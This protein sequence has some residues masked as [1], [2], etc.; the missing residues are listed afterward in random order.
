VAAVT[1]SRCTAR[2]ARRRRR[3]RAIAFAAVAVALAAS[4]SGS[5][6]ASASGSSGLIAFTVLTGKHT[7]IYSSRTDG[8]GRLRLTQGVNDEYCPTWSPDGQ[9]IALVVRQ[10]S[11]SPITGGSW[12]EVITARGKRRWQIGAEGSC[13]AWSPDGKWLAYFQDTDSGVDLNIVG[14]NGRGKRRLAANVD[15]R[16]YAGVPA[17]SPDSRELAYMNEGD[18]ATFLI[19]FVGVD[20]IRR[21]ALQIQ[22]APSFCSDYCQLYA[23]WMTWAPG[24][25][26]AFLIAG[27][28]LYPEVLYAIGRDG[29]NQRL[30]SGELQD[31][32]VPAWAPDGKRIAFITRQ[33]NNDQI[34]V[35]N[36]DG[37]GLRQVTRIRSNTS[38]LSGVFDP[39]WSPD[40]NRLGCWGHA[41]GI[42]SVD[43]TTG[44]AK[45]LLRNAGGAI[46]WQS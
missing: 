18:A 41:G 32:Y 14:A 24:K 20:G 10:P 4:P 38:N 36:A 12:I 37:N 21:P 29:T 35:A 2:F 42:Y 9:S 33:G 11:T 5:S 34:W 30:L 19:R 3:F 44:T 23:A 43:T 25:D 46:S 17:W 26:I 27:G 1:T 13:P 22:R 28:D 16:L 45:L 7:D 15:H 31:N 8:T 39:T 6:L 40:G